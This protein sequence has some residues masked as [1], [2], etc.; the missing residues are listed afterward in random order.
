[1]ASPAQARQPTEEGP[2]PSDEGIAPLSHLRESWRVF[3]AIK[4]PCT[5]G[6]KGQQVEHGGGAAIDGTP[7]IQHD[8]R[9]G[10]V[11]TFKRR[12]FAQELR[13]LGGLKLHRI[14][15]LVSPS[16]DPKFTELAFPVVN[17]TGARCRGMG[18]R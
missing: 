10:E 1:V 7:V 6:A 3:I 11:L 9:A 13:I 18:S 5:L 12:I 8:D 15:N 16:S 14:P 4:E 17:D 2:V